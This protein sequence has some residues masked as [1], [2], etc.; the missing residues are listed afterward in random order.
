ML[1]AAI[2]FREGGYGTPV[3][4]GRQD[5]YDRL[6]A[7]GVPFSQEDG[8]LHLTREGGHSH[9]R[10]VHA[11]DA[12]GAAVQHTLIDRVRMAPNVQVF[13]THNLVDLI[14]SDKH[15]GQSDEPRSTSTW[16]SSTAA[17][18]R[19]VRECSELSLKLAPTKDW[20]AR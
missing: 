20:A 18:G 4:V 13:E 1:R 10:I 11:A 6:R 19:S 7:L 5:V 3:L 14:L 17:P 16:I 15:G 9:R 8:Q 2:Q 12:T